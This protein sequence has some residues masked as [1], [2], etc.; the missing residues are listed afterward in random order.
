[1]GGGGPLGMMDPFGLAAGAEWHHVIP[2]QYWR[3]GRALG[4]WHSLM[5]QIWNGWWL[6][7]SVH[8]ITWRR[9]YLEFV[10]GELARYDWENMTER[11][12][13]RALERIVRNIKR[14]FPNVFSTGFAVDVTYNR[15]RTEHTRTATSR[16]RSLGTLG[17]IL[18]GVFVIS[19][20]HAQNAELLELIH[21]FNRDAE[22]GNWADANS[23][24]HTIA[25][26]LDVLGTG[27]N[28][29]LMHAMLMEEYSHIRSR[30]DA[31]RSGRAAGCN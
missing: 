19:E 24:A 30:R 17:V 1:M 31:E 9:R 20:A 26:L 23:R 4:R 25:Q 18:F 28:V 29:V 16:M 27:V 14:E 11:Q 2:Q 12:A 10:E 8:P 13:K 7:S 21:Q 3:E 22:S 15:R 5:H 6:P